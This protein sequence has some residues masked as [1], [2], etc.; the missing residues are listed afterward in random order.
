MANIHSNISFGLVNI[1]IIMNPI[2]QN[3]D[4]SFNQ[5]HNKC[6][7]RVKYIKYCPYCKKNLLEK[8]IIK[9]YEYSK[10][11]YL[12]F[13]KDE[14]NALKPENDHEIEV[15]SFVKLNEISPIY[16]EKSYFL[17]ADNKS[18]AYP[19]FYEALHKTNLVALAKCIIST[20]FYYCILRFIKEGSYKIKFAIVYYVSEITLGM[21]TDTLDSEGTIIKI[22]KKDIT[23]DEIIKVLESMKG[24]FEPEKYHDEYQDNIKKA[25]DDKLDGKKI[26]NNKKT[27]KTQINDLMKA[28][29]KSL[30]KK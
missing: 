28:L 11:N 1:P 6:L 5:L 3:N 24:K 25:I 29:E 4:T 15:I 14:L 9:G 19:L 16:F 12:I 2:I 10:D 18:K 26:K 21:L 17:K 13:N 7:N 20:K 23:K 30:N 8:D 22:D 27:N